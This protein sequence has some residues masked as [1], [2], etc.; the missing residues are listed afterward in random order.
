[1]NKSDKI[2]LDSGNSLE[3]GSAGAYPAISPVSVSSGFYGSYE[4]ALD[5]KGRVALPA[6]F[7]ALLGPEDQN[8]VVL[9]NFVTDGVRCLDGFGL[10]A[11]KNFETKLRAKGRFNPGVRQLETFYISRA[12]LCS[13]DSNGRINIPQHLREYAGIERDTVFTASLHGFRVWRKE[14]WELVFR[15]A[16]EMLLENPAL[17]EG[18]DS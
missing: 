3:E 17:F 7:R 8:T 11:W 16:E 10:Q 5:S 4:H 14:V 15:Q 2:G 13:F 18:V 6:T 1:M 9:T 12:Q